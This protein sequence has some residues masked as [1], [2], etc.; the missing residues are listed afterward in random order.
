MKTALDK[1][2]KR[3]MPEA[4]VSGVWAFGFAVGYVNGKIIIVIPFVEIWIR[5]N[6]Q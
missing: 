1:S 5:L 3:K 6:R 2:K 4:K